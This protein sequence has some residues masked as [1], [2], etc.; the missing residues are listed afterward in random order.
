[1]D[2]TLAICGSMSFLREMQDLADELVRVG[3]SCLLP[4]REDSQGD[5][6]PSPTL[7]RGYIDQHL[8]KIT[9]SD[10][11]LVANFEKR[12]VS[13]YVGP[14]TLMEMA[15][16]YALHKPIFVLNP[17]GEQPCKEEVLAMQTSNL[18][19]K[20]ANLEMMPRGSQDSLPQSV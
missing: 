6:R 12:G 9:R 13:G 20:L 1:M 11:V 19:G 17:L 3:Y 15:F 7:K 10:A 5:T 16:A 14:N 4:M 8:Q 2:G 18:E